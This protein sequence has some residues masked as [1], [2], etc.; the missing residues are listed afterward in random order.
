M[1]RT[2][3]HS[4]KTANTKLASERICRRSASLVPDKSRQAEIDIIDERMCN[5]GLEFLSEL[6]VGAS[7]IRF[8][9]ALLVDCDTCLTDPRYKSWDCHNEAKGEEV[10]AST[11]EV[12]GWGRLEV[13][14]FGSLGLKAFIMSIPN[15]RARKAMGKWTNAGWAGLLS[16]G[17]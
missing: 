1:V 14:A 4:A 2:Q 7:S 3:Q 9:E 12:G 10:V 11:S 13:T 15:A 16:S 17:Q 5:H 8:E 6:G